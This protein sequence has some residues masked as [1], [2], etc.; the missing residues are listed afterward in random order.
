MQWKQKII[1]LLFICLPLCGFAKEKLTPDFEVDGVSAS[2]ANNA[3]Q[4][5]KVEYSFIKKPTESKLRTF[6]NDANP[7]VLKALKPYGYFRAT[8]VHRSWHNEDK[9][10]T[11]KF[12]VTPGELLK[13]THLNINIAGPG[14]NTP[15]IRQSLKTLPL[16][17]GDVFDVETYH[18]L[19]NQ[20][21]SAAQHDGYIKAY[22]KHD[23]VTIN[24]ID[25][26]STINI[27]LNT[28]VQYKFATT[29]FSKN[30]LSDTFLKRFMRYKKGE[31]FS[32]DKILRLQNDLSSAG[33]YQSVNVT[34]R[35]DHI[36]NRSVPVH[37]KLTPYLQRRFQFGLGMGTVSGLRLKTGVLWR[38]VNRWGHSFSTNVSW[39]NFLKNINFL[40]SIPTKHNPANSSYT[41]GGG[42]YTLKP[43]HADALIKKLSLG[44]VTK[45][46]KWQQSINLSY[47]L[48]RFRIS[49]AIAYQNA[50]LLTPSI[51]W[52]W[53]STPNKLWIKHGTSLMIALSGSD[54]QFGSTVSYGQAQVR[55]KTIQSFLDRNRIVLMGDIGYTTVKDYYKLPV[56]VQYYTGGPN[57]IRGFAPLSIGPGRYLTVG[58]VEYQYRV[59]GNWYAAVFYDTG[60]AFNDFSKYSSELE[61]SGGVGAI[62]ESP[63]GAVRIYVAKPLSKDT[64]AI[65]VDFALGP[66]LQ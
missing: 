22:L 38:W 32:S 7:I 41:I 20:L 8:V 66:E 24:L 49:K 17:E 18:K 15:A 52:S 58:S 14:K 21:L 61:Y 25:Y 44:Y 19:R 31:P 23:R 42:Y 50:R 51:T 1:I 6:Y 65:R 36:K 28:G 34:P 62:W 33:Y 57:S 10:I 2:A 13:V 3:V 37:V 39:S 59:V 35:L 46:Q 55:A 11:L 26:T 43:R 53:I 4:R 56:S 63:I 29:I 48:E 16:K 5:L 12:R 45:H 40:Y 9:K 27:T 54:A 60:S 47:S 64:N 30:P